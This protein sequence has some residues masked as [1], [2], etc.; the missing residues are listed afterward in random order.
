MALALLADRWAHE[1]GGSLVALVVD[2]GLRPESRG[3]A[4][5]TLARL[6]SRD[7][8]TKLLPLEGLTRG[9]AVAQ[10]ARAARLAALSAACT[11][12]GILHLLLGHHAGDQAETVLIRALGGSRSAGMAG[13]AAL[14]ELPRL[15][16][17]RPL[18]TVPSARL[19]AIL[20]GAE[21]SWVED[22]SNRDV[23][24]LRPRLRLLR[25]DHDGEG[26]AT[27]ALVAAAMASGRRRAEQERQTAAE[28]AENATLRP[29]GFALLTRATLGAQALSALIQALSGA[30]FPPA[31]RSVAGLAAAPRPAT[32]GG[33]RLMPAGRLGPGWLAVREPAVMLAP[34]PA[35]PGAVWDRRFRLGDTARPPENATLGAL[36]RDATRLRRLSSLPAVILATL[37]A[38]RR[39]ET[40]LAVPHLNYPDREGCARFPVLFSPPR[41]P[42]AAPFGY[43]DA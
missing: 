29:E 42:C 5:E 3:E 36:G 1:R 35:R 30:D 24:A 16:L 19:R 41:A 32:L 39:G 28:L 37:P 9:P 12:A 20:A 7:I 26:S 2:H 17:L 21:V 38:I 40:L 31:T 23:S 10:R 14:A 25:H 8:Q 18:L 34:V 43:G 11:E 22:P 6:G 33:V 27:T 15:R 4:L 13:M